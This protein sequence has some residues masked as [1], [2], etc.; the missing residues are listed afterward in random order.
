MKALK[1]VVFVAALCLTPQSA[2]QRIEAASPVIGILQTELHRNFSVLNKEQTPAY[3]LGYTVH[4]ERSSTVIASL[5]ALERSDESRGRFAT[6]EVRVGDYALDNTHPLRGDGGGVNPRTGRTSL[7]LTDDDKPIQLALWR[8]TDRA[9]KQATE[10]LTR[11]T[12]NVAAKIKDE[13]PAADFSHEQSQTYAAD[14]AVYT[15]DTK[16]WEAR[17]RRV[18]APFAEDPLIFLSNVSLSVEVDNRYYVNSEGTNLATGELQCRLFIQAMTKADDGMELPLYTSYFSRTING[19][20]DERK[21]IADVREMMTLLAALRKAPIVDPYSG[22]A[23]LSGRAAGVFFHEIF[24]HRVEGHRQRNVDDGQT[25]GSKVNEAILPTFLSVVFDPTLKARGNIELMGHYQ[26]DD[27][28]VPGQRVTVVDRGILKTFL[29]GRAPLTAFPNSNG[30]GRAESGYVPVSRQS[31]LVVQAS[32]TVTS[33]ALLTMLKDEARKQG[34]PFG[35]LFDNIEGGFTVTGRNNPNAFNVMP[36]VVYRVYTDN[37]PPELVR[38]VDLIGTPLAAFGKFIAA[39]DKV[40]VFNGMCGAESG[41][42]PV[43]A[44]SPE[45]LISEVEV[46]KKAQSQETLPILPSP[47]RTPGGGRS[48]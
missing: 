45:L 14:P 30:H 10:Q 44:S 22:P 27:E 34:K 25:F 11:V 32:R 43:S 40:D 19:L 46:Q 2:V 5:G 16:E 28:G 20:P 7:P 23:I 8:A 18:S 39:S 47:P 37:R 1:L 48:F 15:L 42:V 33:A 3:F 41:S 29:L 21:L 38:G 31:N 6:V 9:F 17:L 13:D 26:Y 35:L 4:D 36:N 12:T 24:G